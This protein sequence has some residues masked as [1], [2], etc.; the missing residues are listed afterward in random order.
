MVFIM[1]QTKAIYNLLKL[2]PEDAGLASWATEDLRA[3]SLETLFE[4]LYS[5]GVQV[6]KRAFHLFSEECDTPEE[7]ADLLIPEEATE[8]ERDPIYLLVFEIWRRLLPEKQSLSIF[9]DELDRRISLYDEE[10][11]ESDELIQD[12]LANLLE[13]LD[14]N[15]DAGAAPQEVFSAISDYCAHDLESFIYDYITELLDSGNSLYATELIEGFSAYITEPLWFD[16][17]RLRIL[18]LTDLEEANRAVSHLLANGPELL[19]LLEILRY[20]SVNGDHPLFVQTAR[21][22]ASLLSEEAEWYDLTHLIADYYR[23]C[24][25]DEMEQM[26]L[27]IIKA[28]QKGELTPQDLQ[29]IEK[30]F[31]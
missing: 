1:L 26:V 2:N 21:L 24:D 28:R 25:E 23:R 4:R 12:G 8:E 27:K 17:L 16:F 15:A 9:C 18:S 11:L 29:T 19:L 5:L 13:V 7:M 6:E 20:L 3:L 10:S 30:I 14:E 31:Y 22:A